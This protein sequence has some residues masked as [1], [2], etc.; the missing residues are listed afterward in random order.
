[1][2][3]MWMVAIFMVGGSPAWAGPVRGLV[4]A[5]ATS[6]AKAL[7]KGLTHKKSY[8]RELAA[9]QLAR[10]Q[11]TD[12]ATA[13]L[14]ACVKSS[15]ERGYVRAACASTLAKWGVKSADEAIIAAI[16]EAPPDAKYWLAEALHRLDTPAGRSHIV[17]LQSD[18]DVF[19]A[20]SAREWSR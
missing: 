1:M 11:P 17:G 18:M 9:R 12:S 20:T 6:N 13:L 3:W 15:A 8:A 16:A 4:K 5:G 7:E 14:T 10:L 2:K 19:L